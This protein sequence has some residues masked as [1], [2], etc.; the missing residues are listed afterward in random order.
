MIHTR[1]Y[2][3][4]LFIIA[5]FLYIFIGNMNVFTNVY[6]MMLPRY[7]V[8]IVVLFIGYL[9]EKTEILP[10]LYFRYKNVFEYY[11]NTWLLKCKWYLYI[12]FIMNCAMLKFNPVHVF[13]IYVVIDTGIFMMINDVCN[14]LVII[15]KQ[16][17]YRYVLFFILFVLSEFLMENLNISYLLSEIWILPTCYPM[18]ILIGT[19][20]GFHIILSLVNIYLIKHLDKI[21]SIWN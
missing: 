13:L 9:S 20:V 10:M 8:L 15:C 17:N 11:R 2:V 5:C 7:S 4:I 6:T 14:L 18:G 12:A 16:R 1:R 3:G 19:I 21:N